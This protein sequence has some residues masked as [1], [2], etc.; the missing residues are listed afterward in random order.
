V[1]LV[2][3][4]RATL[5]LER[6]EVGA[7]A[8]TVEAIDLRAPAATHGMGRL[9]LLHQTG[10]IRLA[11]GRP[12]EAAEHFRDCGRRL[13]R[14][15]RIQPSRPSPWRGGLALALAATG[16]RDEALALVHEEV[17]LARAFEVSAGAGHGV[18][19]G[20]TR[21]GGTEGVELLREAVAEL[22]GSPARL[23]H[24]RALTDLGAALRRRGRRASARAPLREALDLAQRCG[25][26][27]LARRAHE[28]LVADR[29]ATAAP[30]AQ[31]RGRAHAE[32]APGGGVRGRRA[33]E[34]RDRP[35]AVRDR[36]DGGDA[37]RPRVPQARPAVAL[38]AAG[39]LDPR[40]SVTP[41]PVSRPVAPSA[42][43]AP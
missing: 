17:R 26:L 5:L 31:R 28:E 22:E 35:G 36:E 18:A 3:G 6:G 42:L 16:E 32:R 25:A 30:R 20:W 2:Q 9:Y 21:R 11:Q 37:P 43:D 39:A 12:A 29:S 7:A 38:A 15:P 33:H 8:A 19:R 4:G 41:G 40:A 1:P 13:T 24:A 10:V 23:E 34:P 14:I 27:A